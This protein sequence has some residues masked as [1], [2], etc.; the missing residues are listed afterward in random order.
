MTFNLDLNTIL[1]ALIVGGLGHLALVVL[2][3]S[4][5][6]ERLDERT[7]QHD[8]RIERLEEAA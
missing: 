7:K 6:I 1:Q 8:K 2:R 5:V 4:R 3:T